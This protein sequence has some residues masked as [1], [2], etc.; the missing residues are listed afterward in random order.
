MES[1]FGQLKGFIGEVWEVTGPDSEKGAQP[2]FWG[3]DPLEV[4]PV[5]DTVSDV[6]AAAPAI[7]YSARFNPAGLS[8]NEERH[9]DFTSTSPSL[10]LRSLAIENVPVEVST[11]R[12]SLKRLGSVG[13][14]DVPALFSDVVVPLHSMSDIVLCEWRALDDC[15][16]SFAAYL[17]LTA[18]DDEEL[19]GQ[20]SH[21][22]YQIEV[23]LRLVPPAE[24]ISGM[25]EDVALQQFSAMVHGGQCKD[26]PRVHFQVSKHY[27][28]ASNRRFNHSASLSMHV[29]Y[30]P[31]DDL[32]KIERE[33]TRV[34]REEPSLGAKVALSQL[35]E[36]GSY[37]C[38]DG[39]RDVQIEVSNL[40]ETSSPNR[41]RVSNRMAAQ[42]EEV[43]RREN[44]FLSVRVGGEVFPGDLRAFLRS[45]AGIDSKPKGR[46]ESKDTVDPPP[47]LIVPPKHQLP[48]VVVL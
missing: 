26:A 8:Q 34:L 24:R 23:W 7:L 47:P 15:G 27:A 29:P 45:F 35:W 22:S 11:L 31:A 46:V 17:P 9:D 28:R 1:I 42:L 4:P 38:S 41:V 21:E 10:M 36:R 19:I 40:L 43:S 18:L 20:D 39:K 3:D 12:C 44:A 14:V 32:D 33:V 2:N 13:N 25:S 16:D 30:L 48:A 37:V 5:D 6:K